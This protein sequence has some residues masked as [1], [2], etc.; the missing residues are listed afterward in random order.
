[1]ELNKALEALRDLESTLAVCRHAIGVLSYDGETIAPRNSAVGRGK[2]TAYLAGIEHEL[3]TGAKTRDLIDTL[4]ASA[5][6]LDDCT[7]RR[8]T[9]IRRDADDLTLIPAKE[10]MDY[11]QLLAE[12]SGVWHVAKPA[13]DYAAFAP[14][15]ERIIDYNIRYAQRKDP[16]KA[17]YDVLLDTYEEGACM[18]DLDPFFDLLRT[19]LTP[20]IL[21][22]KGRPRPD[23]SF[24]HGC[25]P[26]ERQRAFSDRLM[27]LMQLNR[28]DCSIGET[29]HPF[30][31]GLNKHDVR[32]TTHYFENDVTAS[33]FSVI[34]EGGHA[35]YELGSGDEL[36]G[37]YA[38][39][40]STTGI[41]ESQSRFYENL[42][43]RSEAF[44]HAVLPIM[45]E[46]F[47]AQL[48]GVTPQ[49]LYRAFNVAEPSLIR[50]EADELTYGLHVLVRYELE[51][52]MLSGALKVKDIPGEWNRLMHEVLGV[53][54]PDD[55]RGALQD[56][57]WA[58]GLVGYFP[59]YA[60]GSAYGVQMLERMQQDMDV[61]A[62]VAKGDIAPITAWLRQ[63]LHRYGK[64]YAP[65]DVFKN[66]FEAPFDPS[67]YTTYLKDKF[68]A[69]YGL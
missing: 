1:M 49:M 69:L 22:I 57:H 19:E 52:R 56:T 24:L 16:T 13:N 15:L 50:T 53:T 54:V 23:D 6:Q 65:A 59:S 42:I 10:Y 43:G 64:L 55:R 63:R 9:L 3:L 26:I 33:M 68:S 27:A 44:C 36:E 40:G 14:Y 12:A 45:Q 48:Q 21:E 5:D 38:A 35:M 34:H 4:S 31:E 2:T 18:A 11:Q 60:L 8:V 30:T 51:K 41:H 61:Y 29:E 66:V 7:R 46:L 67:K 25:F 62:L 32:I 20:L 47:P 17:P 37:T 28:D 58:S 39:G